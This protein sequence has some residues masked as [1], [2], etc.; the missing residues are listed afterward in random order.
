MPIGKPIANTTAQILDS[1]LQ[2]VAVGVTGELH[3]GGDGLALG[4]WRQPELTAEKFIERNRERLYKT[5]DLA[6]WRADG[7]IEF[8]G[9]ADRQI[10][11]RGFRIEPGEI[12]SAL[13]RQ[14]N[15]RDAVVIL[16][17]D[18][19]LVG[20]YIGTPTAGE[21]LTALRQSL[22]DYMVPS[23]LVSMPELP[24]TSNGKLDRAALPAP[25]DGDKF[26]QPKSALEKQLAAI[27]AKTLGRERV[28]ATDNFFELGGH[29]LLA[30]R[31]VNQLNDSLGSRVP[32]TMIFE[33]PT[34]AQMAE[35]LQRPGVN[36]PKPR[37]PIVSIDRESRRARRS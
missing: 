6:R 25:E 27:W 19:R 35:R 5:G 32:L 28:G 7:V 12:E 29:S 3:L 13:K 34:I 37:P 22:P 14:A 4:Y 18:K 11:L 31:L 33:A 23:A 21:L 30:L 2:P 8:L 20:Y 26:V 15:V 24:R 36:A 16:R 1:N 10:K 17:E 9:R